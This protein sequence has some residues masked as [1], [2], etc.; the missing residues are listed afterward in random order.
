M[1][2]ALARRNTGPNEMSEFRFALDLVRFKRS[3]R[4][5]VVSEHIGQM[6]NQGSASD[7]VQKLA[8][9]ANPKNRHLG[10]S[11][12]EQPSLAQESGIVAEEHVR[13]VLLT[14]MP[15]VDIIAA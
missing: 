10:R 9:V 12:V 3:G 1:M 13:M 11:G 8:A 14:E 2:E 6:L 5:L 4:V 15:S 7:H